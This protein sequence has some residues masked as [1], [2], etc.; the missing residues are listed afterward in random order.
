M[1]IAGRISLPCFAH[2][3]H[4]VVIDGLKDEKIHRL[5]SI[6]KAAV[7]CFHRSTK[8]SNKLKEIQEQMGKPIQKLINST[9][10]R[11]NSTLNM[12]LR[13]LE[14]LEVLEAIEAN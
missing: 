10:T 1:K 5:I 11:W 12:T 8:A 2:T 7:E 13:I 9:P 14:N 6:C 4:L 3:L